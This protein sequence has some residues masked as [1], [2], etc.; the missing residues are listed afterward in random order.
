LPY[1]QS[2]AE[3][4]TARMMPTPDN[5]HGSWDGGYVL[6]TLIENLMCGGVSS[7]EWRVMLQGTDDTMYHFDTDEQQATAIFNGIAECD[8]VSY[9]MIQD[10]GF[11][12]Y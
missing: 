10:M 7:G 2:L 4:C 12:H 11:E 3:R 6:M 5:W 8:S 9:A 1:L